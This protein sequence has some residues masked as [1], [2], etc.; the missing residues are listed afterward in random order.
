MDTLYDMLGVH[1]DA[2]QEQIKRAYRKAAMKFHPDRNVG[3]EAEAHAAFQQI[4]DAYAILSDLE[5][6]RIYD[7]VFAEEMARLE[8]HREEARAKEEAH[9]AQMVALAMRF[10]ER[11]YNR[12]VVFGVLLG[13]DCELELAGRIADG[14]AAWRA[15]HQAEQ[16]AARTEAEAQESEVSAKDRRAVAHETDHELAASEA[17]NE[18]AEA[19]PEAAPTHAGLFGAWWHGLFGLRS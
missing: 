13:R 9:Y 1:E 12:D 6:R 11:D 2:T 17:Q 15:T 14:V 5:Q 19:A 16:D 3:R 10:A 7:E 4:K 8:R 18:S